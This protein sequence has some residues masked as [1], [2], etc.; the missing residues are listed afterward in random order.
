MRINKVLVKELGE[1]LT[2]CQNFA[3]GFFGH[4]ITQNTENVLRTM[5]EWILVIVYDVLK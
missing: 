5:S 2:A 4:E 1:V 3:S